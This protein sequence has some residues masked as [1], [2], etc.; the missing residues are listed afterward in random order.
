MQCIYG[1]FGRIITKYMVI[2]DAYTYGS[3]QPCKCVL[4]ISTHLWQ[5][6]VNVMPANN[7]QPLSVSCP[8]RLAHTDFTDKPSRRLK[9]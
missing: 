2:Y 5:V 7:Y 4:V 9:V 3:G 6:G 8:H 1:M